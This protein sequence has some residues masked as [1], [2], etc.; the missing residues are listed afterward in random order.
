M[1]INLRCKM[2]DL[3]SVV[4]LKMRFQIIIERLYCISEITLLEA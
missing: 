3:I 2:L 1:S 4:L